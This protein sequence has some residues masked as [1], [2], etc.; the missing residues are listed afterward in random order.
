M[1]IGPWNPARIFAYS[2]DEGDCWIWRGSLN[3]TGYG[4]TRVDGVHWAAHRLSWA[5][6]NGPIPD[7]LFVCHRC[8]NRRCVK[9]AH[10][11]LGT[12]ADNNADM[13]AKGRSRPGHPDNRGEKNPRAKLSE[14][15]VMAIRDALSAGA[16]GCVLARQ[17]SVSKQLISAIRTGQR[18]TR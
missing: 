4:R 15:D 9:P 2:E 13:I 6:H 11:F 8:D 17:Y 3:A 10:L 7:G 12:A 14:R 16:I 1:L 18:W 5:V